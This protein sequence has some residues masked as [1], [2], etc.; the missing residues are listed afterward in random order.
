MTKDV[1]P[2]AYTL[3]P[4][5]DPAPLYKCVSCGHEVRSYDPRDQ[6]FCSVCFAKW[7]AKKFEMAKM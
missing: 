4:M 5:Y 1:R 6:V 2:K 3:M 7:A